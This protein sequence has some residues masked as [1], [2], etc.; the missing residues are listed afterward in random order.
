MRE[1][2]RA[3][4]A[5]E[6]EASDAVDWQ[7]VAKRL[8]AEMDNYRKRQKR[9]AQDEIVQEKAR[10]LTRFLD[11]ADNLEH[12]LKHVKPEDP[13]HQGLQMAYDSMLNLLIREGA[14]RIFAQ[15][16][17]FDPALHEAI[18]MVPAPPDQDAEMKVVE[19]MAPGYRFEERVL[20]PSKVVVA[21]RDA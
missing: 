11:V 1:A 4:D 9:W 8:R 18:A 3:R 13:T 5:A 21:K 17:S 15:G 7:D 20:R 6:N 10:L 14:E 12:A 2:A 19:V 16:R